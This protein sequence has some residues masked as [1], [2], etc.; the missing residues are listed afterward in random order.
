MAAM[1]CA[2]P[3][4]SPP[5]ADE[6]AAQA[7]STPLPLA[8]PAT[9]ASIA[10]QV[11]VLVFVMHQTVLFKAA[12]YHLL[13]FRVPEVALLSS[14][15]TQPL[16]PMGSRSSTTGVRTTSVCTAA[17]QLRGC[18]QGAEAALVALAQRFGDQMP[19]ALPELWA[20]ASSG[21]PQASTPTQPQVRS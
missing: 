2:D 3:G 15:H 1:A 9:E 7:L 19:T 10:R 4:V 13:S 12:G 8:V 5:A 20:A 18:V 11:A 21:L 16:H 14:P 17:Q 6:A